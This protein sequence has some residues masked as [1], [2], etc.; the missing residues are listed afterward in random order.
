MPAE[1][2]PTRRRAA[3]L[4][5]P[6]AHSLSPVLHRAA[7]EALGL[8]WE[9]GRHDVGA[10]ELPGFVAALDG[11]WAGLSLT[12]PLKEAIRPLLDDVD[13]VAAATGSVNTVVL[14]S[15]GRHGW[16]TDVE[17]IAVSL[18]EQGAGTGPATVLGAGATARSAAAAV[19]GRGAAE[20]VVVARRPEAA[21]SVVATAERLG[22][23]AQA[24]GWGSAGEHLAADVVVS[25]VPKGAADALVPD[26]PGHP[27]CLLDV[28]YDP[29]PTPLATA[30]LAA[31][32]R[33]ASGLDM[34][35]HQAVRQVELMTGQHPPV[36]VLRAAL[37]SA[38][39]ER[40]AG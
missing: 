27:G 40:P 3:V 16:N 2:A 4:G 11:S 35:L 26:V 23:R 8:D 22:A 39:A 32:G 14:D 38:A 15:A 7:Y 21:A 29:W 36:E 12:M 28:V 31:G 19:V 6:V 10:D 13:P 18:D 20:V 33:V 1:A 25:T 24:V 30:W 34:L 9:Y 17:G 37:A 5:R